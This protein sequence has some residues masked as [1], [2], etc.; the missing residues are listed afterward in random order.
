[1]A[2]SP[3]SGPG[4][5]KESQPCRAHLGPRTE[6]KS[7]N[8]GTNRTEKIGRHNWRGH[9][10]LGIRLLAMVFLLGAA[11]S[12]IMVGARLDAEVPRPAAAGPGSLPADIIALT[13]PADDNEPPTGTILINNDDVFTIH[14]TVYLTLS[15][16]DTVGVTQMRFSHDGQWQ[17]WLTYATSDKITLTGRDGTT[18]IQVQYRDAAGKMY[19]S[20][21]AW[22]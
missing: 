22:S 12:P 19:R 8:M 11:A 16:S 14:P 20:G 15:A 9:I 18:W 1:M 3:G 10:P 17:D 2:L 13:E 21:S 7:A 4:V 6:E 5:V